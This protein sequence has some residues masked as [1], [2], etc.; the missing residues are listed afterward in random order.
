MKLTAKQVQATYDFLRA[1][2]PFCNWR[3]PESQSVI[4]KV[5]NS[6]MVMGEYESDPHMVSISRVMNNNYDDV[7]QTVAHEMAHLACEKD[8]TECHADHGDS[9]KAKAKEVCD[10]WGWKVEKF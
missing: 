5:S 3:I 9:F 4:I 10:V 6:Q 7:L 2:P 1:M 8:G